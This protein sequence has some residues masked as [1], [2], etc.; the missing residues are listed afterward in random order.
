MY[1]HALF[2]IVLPPTAT[3]RNA[4][5]ECDCYPTDIS[6][7]CISQNVVWQI[8][9][10]IVIRACACVHCDGAAIYR[11][12]GGSV[13]QALVF[14]PL[15]LR[16]D[17]TVDSLWK[18]AIR[19]CKCCLDRHWKRH[20]IYRESDTEF[21]FVIKRCWSTLNLQT[22]IISTILHWSSC[23]FVI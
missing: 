17:K 9:H 13:V 22:G 3:V 21:K 18:R 14:Y 7:A 11:C 23:E 20:R 12:C 15:L 6:E 16:V 8:N 4:F 2:V 5:L 1:P 10:T 19:S